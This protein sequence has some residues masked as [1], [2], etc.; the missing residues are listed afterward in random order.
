[1]PP[2]SDATFA[3]TPQRGWQMQGRDIEIALTSSSLKADSKPVVC[4]RW[5]LRNAAGK[6]V[7]AESLRIVQQSPATQQPG[8]LKVAVPLPQ[9]GKLGKIPDQDQGVYTADNA[10]PM[11][12][13]RLLLLGADGSPVEDR[14]TTLAIVAANDYCNVPTLGSR[15]D[16]GAVVPGASKSWQPVGGEIEFVAQASNVIPNDAIIKPCFR[17]KLAKVDPGPFSDSGPLRVLERQP[18]EQQPTSIKLAV[19]VPEI[20]NEPSRWFGPRIGSFASPHLLVPQADVRVLLFNNNLDPVLDAWTKAGVT[21][22]W[23]AAAIAIATV[24]LTFLALWQ[25]CRKRIPTFGRTNPVICLITTRRGFASLSQ[26]QIML[27][28]FVVIASAA[29]VIA[30]SGDLI[31]ITAGTLV[32]LGI[33]GTAGVMAKAKSENDAAAPPLPLE[34]AAASAEATRA[35]ADERQAR[36]AANLA[37]GPAKAEADLAAEEESLKAEAARKKRQ[38]PRRSQPLPG[39]EPT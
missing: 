14:T 11:A 7:Q 4:F 39:R 27:W 23:F 13:V 38:Q 20:K 12:D 18:T 25:V 21:S 6:F 17:W 5:Q 29:Y 26:F 36:I 22:V 35:E 34:P 33:S 16:S 10:A 1:M 19:T 8:T 28:T 24:G 31:P 15:M 2:A 3:L 37:T 32:L 9:P 30:L